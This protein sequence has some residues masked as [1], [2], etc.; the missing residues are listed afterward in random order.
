[1]EESSPLVEESEHDFISYE[2]DVS[3][4]E[5]FM[6]TLMKEGVVA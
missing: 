6:G 2:I 1:V 3:Y 4:I 5:W